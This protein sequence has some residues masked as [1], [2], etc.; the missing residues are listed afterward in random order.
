MYVVQTRLKH[1]LEQATTTIYYKDVELE[2]VRCSYSS[3]TVRKQG[4]RTIYYWAWS[5]DRYILSG[6]ARV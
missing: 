1:Y 6:T 4:H 2:E 3:E 5:S